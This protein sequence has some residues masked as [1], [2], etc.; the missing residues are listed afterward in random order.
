MSRENQGEGPGRTPIDM[1]EL[2]GLAGFLKEWRTAAGLKLGR[3][4]KLSQSEVAHR[5]GIS[6]RWYS[7]LERG[8]SP[9]MSRENIEQLAEALVLDNDQRETLY[10]YMEAGAPPLSVSTLPSTHALHPLQQLLDQ[11][12]PRPAY[13]SDVAWNIVGF[14][15]AMAQWFPWVLDAGANL[16]RWALLNP[17]ARDQLVDWEE[18]ARVFLAMLRSAIV[19]HDGNPAVAGVLEQ[20]LTDPDC[21]RLWESKPE[22]IK[23]REG[24]HFHLT[25]PRFDYEH[26]EVVSRVLI[27]AA[28]EDLRFVVITWL[29]SQVDPDAPRTDSLE[30][31]RR[32]RTVSPTGNAARARP[33]WA[34]DTFEEA[35]ALAGD[36][37]VDLPALAESIGTDTRLTLDPTGGK[38]IWATR[39]GS[40]PVLWEDLTAQQALERIP[41]TS[42]TAEAR[43][44]Y[45]Q[46][47]RSALPPD[48]AAARA[49]I[50]AL[51]ARHHAALSLLA[52]VSD[53]LP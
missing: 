31:K 2:I 24:H 21:K 14:N 3:G 6:V 39:E 18:H 44:E 43:R 7:Q 40:Q 37:A 35:R 1:G 5:A 41:T 51:A 49:E 15:R 27:P 34:V 47:L 32:T 11:Q 4:K 33:Y 53:D 46:L 23:Y 30:A 50:E 42:L 25:I 20:V 22:L 8:A 29:G 48:A 16:M 36:Q 19:R 26:T 28:F 52:E 45:R 12:I 13:L 10:F 9:R 38:V 17:D